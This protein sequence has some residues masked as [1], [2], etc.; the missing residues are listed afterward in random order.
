VAT[1]L[2]ALRLEGQQLADKINDTQIADA[3]WLVF[4][5]RGI[6]A[7]YKRVCKVNPDAFYVIVD[8]NLSGGATGNTYALPATFRTLLGLTYNPTTSA[9]YNVPKYNF[10]ERNY[11][12]SP[13]V[14]LS[15]PNCQHRRY[16]ILGLTLDVEPFEFAAGSYRAHFRQAPTT[17][18]ADGD[19]ID[20]ILEPFG[21]YIACFAARKGTGIEE[22]DTAEVNTRMR[23]IEQEIVDSAPNDMTNDT[24]ADTGGW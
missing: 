23:E 15:Y 24:I 9:R 14:F 18:V 7:L 6:E 8:F 17:L 11:N 13:Y 10:P 19:A 20:P 5:N 3:S 21:E 2:A 4:I 1:T 16:R 12:A 22:S